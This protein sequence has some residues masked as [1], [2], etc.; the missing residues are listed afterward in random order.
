MKNMLINVRPL[1]KVMEYLASVFLA[2]LN[3]VQPHSFWCNIFH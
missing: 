3:L 2:N 1:S